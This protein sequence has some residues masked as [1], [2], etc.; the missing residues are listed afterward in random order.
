MIPGDIRAV[1]FDRIEACITRARETIYRD[2]LA[3]GPATT[4]GLADRLRMSI[5]TVR[6]RVT[7]LV[8]LGLVRLAAKQSAPGEGCYEAIPLDL[9]RRDHEARRTGVP[10]Q[11]QFRFGA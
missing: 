11:S 4:R 3:N 6:P 10:V 5:L 9:A 8:Q 1:A 2:L 7:E